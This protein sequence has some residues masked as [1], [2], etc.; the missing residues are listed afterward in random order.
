L[1][2]FKKAGWRHAQV[3]AVWAVGQAEPW[4][5][6]TS[7]RATATRWRDYAQRWAIEIVCPQ[8]TKAGAETGV[9]RRDDVPDL[10]RT[11]CHDHTV[12]EQLYHLPALVKGGVRQRRAQPG[13][14]VGDG[15][16]DGAHLDQ[17]LPLGHEFALLQRGIIVLEA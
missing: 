6:V 4:L 8:L 17:A 16:R 13:Q 7:L 15:P 11:I 14:E 12:D 2:V 1:A 5:L 3:V 9:G 10:H